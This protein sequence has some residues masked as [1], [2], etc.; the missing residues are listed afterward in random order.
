MKDR[1]DSGDGG[2][3]MLYHC[4]AGFEKKIRRKRNYHHNDNNNNNG[5]KEM[6]IREMRKEKR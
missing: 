3:T 4:I 6:Q 1:N 2:R 5:E